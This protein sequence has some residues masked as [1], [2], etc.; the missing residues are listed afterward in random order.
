M[1]KYSS[2]L[3]VFILKYSH[4][5]SFDED[6]FV[7]ARSFNSHLWLLSCGETMNDNK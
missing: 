6:T 5:F 1:Y 4:F 3:E 2:D 7:F